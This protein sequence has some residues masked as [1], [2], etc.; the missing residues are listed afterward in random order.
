MAD[1]RKC[2]SLPNV[3]IIHSTF[4]AT[5]KTNS[6]SFP[7]GPTGQNIQPMQELRLVGHVHDGL[8]RAAFKGISEDKQDSHG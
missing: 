3:V 6:I 2:L 8:C 4:R 1:P 5:F 7:M